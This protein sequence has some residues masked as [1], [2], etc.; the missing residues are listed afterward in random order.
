M[1]VELPELL[2][3]DA[4]GWRTWLAQDQPEPRG[5]WLILAKK[6]PAG[7]TSLTYAQ[8]LDEALCQGWID[9]QAGRRDEAT[10]R[11]RFTPRRARSPWSQRNVGLVERL[12]AEGRMQPG[13][14]A[15][16]VRARGDGRW[17]AAYAGA[18]SIE[19]PAD[20]AAALAAEPAAAAMF[21]LLS[22]Q[23]RYAVLYRLQAIKRA[24]T[25]TR[26]VQEYVAMLGR[27][28]TIYPQRRPGVAPPL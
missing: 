20:L 21:D 14:L 7:P 25:R 24:D 2:V 19:V 28:E 11:Q 22:G 15:E 17:A 5:V 12:T 6:G 18:A 9:G 1:A 13:G 4:A 3:P 8:A 10:Y 23:N 16:V 26:R 27:G